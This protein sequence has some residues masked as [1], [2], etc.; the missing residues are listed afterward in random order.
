MFNNSTSEEDGVGK[1]GQEEGY[2]LSFSL[3][4]FKSRM[5]PSFSLP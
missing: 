4:L 2:P 3:S 5:P 1:V